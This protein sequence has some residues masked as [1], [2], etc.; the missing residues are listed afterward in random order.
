MCQ[1]LLRS[2]SFQ[3]DWLPVSPKIY[4]RGLQIY[5]KFILRHAVNWVLFQKIFFWDFLALLRSQSP[6]MHLQSFLNQFF[7]EFP[8]LHLLIWEEISLR[9]FQWIFF[10]D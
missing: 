7:M 2:S 10:K 5:L 1:K 4:F 9:N 3:E 6:E 8:T